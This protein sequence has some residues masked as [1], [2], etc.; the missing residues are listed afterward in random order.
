MKYLFVCTIAVFAFAISC[1]K[2]DNKPNVGKN[3]NTIQL[4]CKIKDK[5]TKECM[6]QEKKDADAVM[7]REWKAPVQ[8]PPKPRLN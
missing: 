1:A 7:A 3:A 6:A 8:E 2:K 4:D 5:D